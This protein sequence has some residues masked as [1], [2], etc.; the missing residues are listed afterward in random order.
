LLKSF[1]PFF[2]AIND[3]KITN[4]TH[5]RTQGIFEYRTPRIGT[6]ICRRESEKIR[7]AVS[8]SALKNFIFALKENGFDNLVY[9]T[10]LYA[11]G[12]ALFNIILKPV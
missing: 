8:P 2:S 11:H 4:N 12:I 3:G 1:R 5:V 10:N 6:A 9:L 7:P